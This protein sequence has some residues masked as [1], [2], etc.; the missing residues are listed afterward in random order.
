MKRHAANTRLNEFEYRQGRTV[1][2]SWPRVIDLELTLKCN[3]NCVMCTSPLT[4]AV[5][6]DME[7]LEKVSPYLGHCEKIIWNDTGE[8]FASPRVREF[9][10]LAKRY[11]PPISYLST[12][13]LLVDRYLDDILDSGLTQMAVSIHAA[14][15]ETYERI[16]RGGRWDKLIANLELMQRKKVERQTEWP[17]LIFHFVAMRS[18]LPELPDYVDFAKKYG[19]SAI[20]VLKLLPTPRDLDPSEQPSPDEEKAAYKKALIRAR[21]LGISIRHSLLNNEALLEEIQRES[22]GSG[23]SSETSRRETTND[24]PP[25]SKSPASDAAWIALKKLHPRRFDMLSDT[26]PGCYLPWQQLVV[27]STGAVFACCFSTVVMGD[28]HVQSLPEIWN[29]PAFQAFRQRLAQYDFSA[30]VPCPFLTRARAYLAASAR[31]SVDEAEP[32]LVERNRCIEAYL[33]DGRW[34]LAYSR[35]VKAGQLRSAVRDARAAI[36]TGIRFLWNT[37]FVRPTRTNVAKEKRGLRRLVWNRV[38][39]LRED[40]ETLSEI[41]TLRARLRRLR[42]DVEILSEAVALRAQQGSADQQCAGPLLAEDGAQ[43][44]IDALFYSV[45][46]VRHETPERLKAGSETHVPI[47][48]MNTSAV[49]WPTEGDHA[50]KIAYNWYYE[51]DAL[52]ILDGLRTRIACS[53]QPGQ[54]FQTQAVLRAPDRPGRYILKWDLVYDPYAWFKDRGSLPL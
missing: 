22:P 20:Q 17:N 48:I 25:N 30:C 33:N 5:D 29:G 52:C 49:A 13:F 21:E 34:L 36:R 44:P 32:R 11:R 50:V 41:V 12:N 18:N 7:C 4:R 26:M 45:R 14:S 3:L 23:Q 51:N 15:R 9:L 16:Q 38:L 1:L 53:L 46:F 43:D 6:L 42:E 31:Q 2:H 35:R 39:R 8:L 40:V 27:E 47:T 19:A 28:L 24:A 37:F 10:E 54:T